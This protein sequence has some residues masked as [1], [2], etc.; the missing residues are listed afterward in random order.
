[1]AI[2]CLGFVTRFFDPPERNVPCLNSCI[3]LAT[4]LL[5][6]A[7]Y[8][9]ANLLLT[10]LATIHTSSSVFRNAD[11]SGGALAMPNWTT[12]R[13]ARR[14]GLGRCKAKKRTPQRF[15]AA[16]RLQMVALGHGIHEFLDS[17]HVLLQF[18][19]D[20]VRCLCDL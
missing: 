13:R 3:T 19:F 6:P 14:I 7:P 4:F 12:K 16:F 15:R 10:I 11:T 18:D 2:A 9:L 8:F 17:G 1:M 20:P 5:A